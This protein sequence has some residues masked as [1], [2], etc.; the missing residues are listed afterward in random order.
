MLL[1]GLPE[2]GSGLALPYPQRVGDEGASVDEQRPVQN[3]DGLA[4]ED[5]VFLV[6][7]VA[8]PVVPALGA[9]PV[10]APHLEKI[11]QRPASDVCVQNEVRRFHLR[12]AFGRRPGYEPDR[13]ARERDVDRAG[14]RGDR[15]GGALGDPPA[16]C[17][18]LRSRASRN[19]AHGR[20]CSARVPG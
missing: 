4:L 7:R 9:L 19:P 15:G 10:C 18:G 3:G 17:S 13:A 2:H 1:E 14:Q 16:A 5:E 6:L 8:D 12:D 11:V 20:P